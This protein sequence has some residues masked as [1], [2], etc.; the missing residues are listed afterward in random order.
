MRP[1]PRRARST[2]GRSSS[3]SPART[4]SATRPPDV[5]GPRPPGR[6]LELEV[7]PAALD[8]YYDRQHAIDT[9]FA[10]DES[11][12][13]Y[14]ELDDAGRYHGLSYYFGPGDGC[15]YCF[16]STV[17]SSSRRSTAA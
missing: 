2:T 5:G 11:R 9:L 14:F 16:D 13:V 10:D 1:G 8:D 17:K 3:S 12:V 6:R 15:G 4:R 7:R